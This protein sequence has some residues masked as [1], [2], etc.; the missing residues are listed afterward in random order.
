MILNDPQGF[1]NHK[2]FVKYVNP[3]GPNGYLNC[4]RFDAYLDRNQPRWTNDIASH[5]GLKRYGLSRNR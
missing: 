5:L 4:R 1:L 3:K 2:K